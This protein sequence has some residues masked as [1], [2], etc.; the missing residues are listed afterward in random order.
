M[1]KPRT[2]NHY[3]IVLSEPATLLTPERHPFTTGFARYYDSPDG[4]TPSEPRIFIRMDPGDLGREVTAIVDTAAPWCILE[5][6]LGTAVKDRNEQL[7]GRVVLSSRLGRFSGHL[8]LGTIKLLADQ[9]EDLDVYATIF[10]SP[11]WPG[12]NFVGY[13]GF[14]DRIRFA[15]DPRDNIFHFGP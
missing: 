15:F 9:G 8:H 1:Q 2:T 5:P 12:G 13:L 11:D 14:L 4:S 10:I 6:K 3:F 7:P